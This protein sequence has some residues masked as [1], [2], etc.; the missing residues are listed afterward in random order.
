MRCG[1]ESSRLDKT[2]GD[3]LAWLCLAVLRKDAVGALLGSM[4]MP[5]QGMAR[6][7]GREKVPL[8]LARLP[9]VRAV[10]WTVRLC[11]NGAGGVFENKMLGG[12]WC[13]RRV[14]GKSVRL[15]G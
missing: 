3:L 8:C 10:L 12:R 7:I 11:N 4:R 9:V 5:S 6:V 1:P 13:L 2:S 14:R 15:V